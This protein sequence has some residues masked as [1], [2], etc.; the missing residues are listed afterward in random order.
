MKRTGI[1]CLTLCIAAAAARAQD[2]WKPYSPPCTEREDVFAF[3][4]K[5]AVKLVAKD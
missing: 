1:V 5:P 2:P 3:T 4:R